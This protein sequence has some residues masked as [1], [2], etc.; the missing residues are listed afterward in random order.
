MLESN[1]KE[2]L[3]LLEKFDT[4]VSELQDEVDLKDIK[5]KY[6]GV[7]RAS[8]RVGKLIWTWTKSNVFPLTR[9]RSV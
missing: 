7:T 6:A 5:I 1:N 8:L 9:L 2:L 3:D 4:K